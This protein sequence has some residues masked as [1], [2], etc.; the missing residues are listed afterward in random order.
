MYFFYL[1]ESGERN[2]EVKR[3]EPFVMLALG[4]HE[5]Q[6]R[7]FETTLNGRKLILIQNIFDRTGIRLDLANAEVHSVDIRIPKNRAQHLFLRHLTD[8]EMNGLM[9]LFYS[10]L[11]TRHFTLMA[12]VVDKACLLDYM[13]RDKVT[14]KVYEL[15]L[16]RGESFI[17][18]EHPKQ[19]A[20]FVLDNTSKELNR[21]IAMKHAYF[22][23]SQ[24]SAG[25]RLQHV[26]EMPFFVE[27]Y[28]SNGVQLADLCAYN[29]YRAFRSENERYPHFQRLLPFFYKSSLTAP[30]KIDGLKIFPDNHRWK[31]LMDRIQKQRARMLSPAAGP[32]K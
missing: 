24:T 16:E 21:S 12:V 32:S 15:L 27:S 10:Q 5:Y 23:R 22:Q 8:E 4:L 18:N 13:D 14:K 7:R 6:S 28:L 20:I 30:E 26:V 25:V 9:E 1:D 29:V 2:P 31:D 3:D 19:Q 17:G 11:E